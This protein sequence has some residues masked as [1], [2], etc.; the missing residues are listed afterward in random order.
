VLSIVDDEVLS[1]TIKHNIVLTSCVIQDDDARRVQD[2][3]PVTFPSGQSSTALSAFAKEVA[4]FIVRE[5]KESS[6]F[7]TREKR[8]RR[9]KSKVQEALEREKAT[10]DA[11]E[12]N[13]FLVS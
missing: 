9:G 4:P 8:S 2:E 7:G 11:E 6:G 1:H 13:N 10:E 3:A 5:L 12:R